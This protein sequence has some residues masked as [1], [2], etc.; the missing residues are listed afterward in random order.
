MNPFLSNAYYPDFPAMTPELAR[1]AFDQLLP[2]AEKELTQYEERVTSIADWETLSEDL[3]TLTHPLFHAWSLLTHLLSVC[4][5][6]AWRTLHETVQP[7]IIAFSNRFSQS[8]PIFDAM[9]RI[10]AQKATLTPTQQRIL[11]HALRDKRLAGIDLP[12]AERTQLNAINTE[13]AQLSMAF[14]NHVLDATKAY[15]LTLATP[16]E[17][18]GLPEALLQATQE[19]GP[20]NTSRW[21]ITLAS[22]VYVPF[23]MHSRNRAAREA[24]YRA[25]VTRASAGELDNTPLINR[26]LEL[27]RQKAALLGFATFADLSLSVKT[28][29]NVAAVDDLLYQLATASHIPGQ[30]EMHDLQVFAAQHPEWAAGADPHAPLKPWDIAFWSERQREALYDYNE[31]ELSRYFPFPAVLNG[32]FKLA[33]DLFDITIQEATGTVPVWHPDVRFFTVST[34]AGTPIAGFY[35]D[36]YSR[37]ETKSSGAWMNEIHTRRKSRDGSIQLPLALMVCNQSLPVDTKPSLLRF[38]EVTTLFHE[39]GHV[40]QHIL[41]TIDEADASGINGVEWDAVEIASQF[42][43]NWCYDRTVLQ[44][45]SAHVETGSPLPD[46]LFQKI[47]A[48]KNYRSAS[49]MLRQLIF[50]TVD[51]TLHAHYPNPQKWPD[52]HALDH[53][54]AQEYSPIKPLDEDRFLCAFSHIFGGGYA[55]GYYSYKWSEVM[56]ADLFAAFEEAGLHDQQAIA[57]EGRRLR[58]TL[59]SLGGAEDPMVVFERFRGRKP[60][61]HALLHHAGLAR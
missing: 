45:M 44:Q 15:T 36:P 54:I 26:I 31:T 59:F 39:F 51:M 20:D 40:L 12:E 43:E 28:A 23:M 37:P 33:H 7:R 61:I 32:L 18:A 27:R 24:L 11:D 5:T 50:A 22:A 41:T 1:D 38:G 47:V 16:E 13:L 6:D 17:I 56:S 3:Y 34:T 49:A 46:E 57:R 60:N 4:N 42:M 52:V 8:K 21:K 58:D 19:I 35:L 10:A 30:T 2:A 48:S 9:A 53:A 55:A 29:K 25:Y 14:S